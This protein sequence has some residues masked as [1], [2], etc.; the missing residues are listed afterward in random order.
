MQAAVS[1][2]DHLPAL[3]CF[4]SDCVISGLTVELLGLSTFFN[5]CLLGVSP[6]KFPAENKTTKLSERL[7][8]RLN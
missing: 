3:P 6:I 5:C 2:V 7:K 4:P 8:I 1:S